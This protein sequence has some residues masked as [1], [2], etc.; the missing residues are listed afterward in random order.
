MLKL[1][2]Y[3]PVSSIF[4]M[5]ASQLSCIILRPRHWRKT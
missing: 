4:N 5:N 2:S 1:Y 3:S